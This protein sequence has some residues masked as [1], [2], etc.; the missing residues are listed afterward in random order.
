MLDVLV[1]SPHPDDAELGAG[2][3]IYKATKSGLKVGIIDLTAGEMGSLGSKEIR[4]QE[5][6]EAK[7]ILN[8]EF[9][10]NLEF[11]DGFLSF[12]DEKAIFTVAKKIREFEPKIVLIPYWEDRHPDHV[13]ASYIITKAIHY[14]KLKKIDLDYPHHLVD[15]VLYYEIN[16]QFTPPSF[17]MDISQ[18]FAVK[19]KAI[20]SFQSQ[21]KEFSKEYLPFP[22]IERCKYYGSIV[23]C[24]YGEAFLLKKPIKLKEWQILF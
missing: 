19:Q 12:L 2:G 10:E 13:A 9:R 14:S 23:S 5:A 8:L 18:E 22:L 6:T 16:G 1:F 4:L 21:F 11:P 24:E 7:R 20:M 17:I 3:A 15:D